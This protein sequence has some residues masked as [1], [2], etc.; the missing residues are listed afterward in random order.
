M[1]RDAGGVVEQCAGSLFLV[2]CALL[3]DWGLHA[4]PS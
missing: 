3:E 1:T 4:F 2:N